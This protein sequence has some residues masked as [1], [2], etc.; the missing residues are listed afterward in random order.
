MPFRTA[1][2]RWLTV[3]GAAAAIV[4]LWLWLGDS[5]LTVLVTI[6]GAFVPI[7]VLLPR[8]LAPAPSQPKQIDA[9]AEA[10]TRSVR[11]QW[12]AEQYRRGLEDPHSMPI[13]WSVDPNIS[14]RAIPKGTPPSGELAKIV[15]QFV[16]RP[17]RLVVTGGPGSGKTGLC[18]VLTLELLA[19][20][21]DNQNIP[22]L[23]PLSSWNSAENLNTW[24]ARRLAEDYPWLTGPS[25]YG[26][27]AC[28]ELVEQRRILPLLD[29]LDEVSA[30]NRADV[31]GRL[32]EDLAGQP[33]VLTC[34][35]EEWVDV[36]ANGTFDDLFVVQ[37]LP[38][39]PDVAAG[40]LLEAVS[41][42]DLDRWDTVLSRLSEGSAGILETVCTQPWTLFLLQAVYRSPKSEPSELLDTA[43]FPSVERVEER[44]LDEFV[45]VAF[46]TRPPSP[47]QAKPPARRW[48]PD[49]SEKGMIF[50]AK[51]LHERSS[52]EL[53][54]WELAALLPSWFS[55]LLRVSIAS[56]ADAA[57]CAVLFGLFGRPWL[58]AV[59]GFVTGGIVALAL[60]LV[61]A[62]R[63]RR[64]AFSS[65]RRRFKFRSLL[66]AGFILVGTFGGGGIVFILYGPLPG[67][68]A[69]VAFGSVFAVVRRLIEPTEPEDAISPASVLRDDRR[70]VVSAAAI[71]WLAGA[72]VGG[73]L[74]GLVAGHKQGLIWDLNPWE[75]AAL[76]AVVGA[77]LCSAALG[78]MMHSNSASGRFV[79]TQLWLSSRRLTPVPLI[80]FL[81]EARQLGVLRQIGP[82]YQ[83]RHASLQDRLAARPLP[84]DQSR[85]L[86]ASPSW[87]RP[88]TDRQPGR[89]G[90]APAAARLI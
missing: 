17:S 51:V 74:G 24:L 34:R 43:R 22:Y 55:P 7:L 76:G 73:L 2:I 16:A 88:R 84:A 9:A 12:V 71:G 65:N 21:S 85:R 25:T 38:L 35:S 50:L 72:V 41:G 82:Y 57:L 30:S 18:V 3:A 6:V 31:L 70:L 46:T 54:W 80:A 53:A 5:R 26:A 75:Q 48:D 45:R 36:Q 28:A 47:R 14:G 44:L 37:L 27:T 32:L 67:A 90:R 42:S 68:L 13:Q 23:V 52:R 61:P 1:P 66:D 10:L 39:K 33:F 58:G 62:E 64:L 20:Q 79:T 78:A 89:A 4:V 40:Y 8:W 49:R 29:G 19:D 15:E 77:T 59:F 86:R 11:K 60:G 56:I 69:G 81:D 63:P 87:P 83:F